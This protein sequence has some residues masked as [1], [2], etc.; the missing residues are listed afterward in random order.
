[1]RQHAVSS[2]DTPVDVNVNVNVLDIGAKTE[3][4]STA[5]GARPAGNPKNH[6]AATA[7]AAAMVSA[8]ILSAS[9]S[10]DAAR[11][12]Q[13]SLFDGRR[14]DDHGQQ[15]AFQQAPAPI[16]VDPNSLLPPE[17]KNLDTDV[18][19]FKRH[20]SI[21]NA[22]AGLSGVG[23]PT[24]S[25]SPRPFPP[26]P[27]RAGSVRLTP[28]EQ[29][30][31]FSS[32]IRDAPGQ[33]DSPFVPRTRRGLRHRARLEQ[34]PRLRLSTS[35][36]STSNNSSLQSS[37]AAGALNTSVQSLDAQGPGA[38]S[39]AVDE[40]SRYYGDQPAYLEDGGDLAGSER[41]R[42]AGDAH[43]NAP[44][45]AVATLCHKVSNAL[46][47]THFGSQ[48]L[49]GE[50][51]DG[52]FRLGHLRLGELV[53]RGGS[54]FNATKPRQRSSSSDSARSPGAG[55]AS[56]DADGTRS[57]DGG[58]PN[59][60][61]GSGGRD[62]DDPDDPN[63]DEEPT[64]GQSGPPDP[65]DVHGNLNTEEKRIWKEGERRLR[66]G[67]LWRQFGQSMHFLTLEFE[68]ERTEFEFQCDYTRRNKKYVY[69]GLS[70]GWICCLLYLLVIRAKLL[71]WVG[72]WLFGWRGGLVDDVVLGVSHGGGDSAQGAAAENLE[73]DEAAG[74]AA[75]HGNGQSL[76]QK[77]IQGQLWTGDFAYDRDLN[78]RL[79]KELRLYPKGAPIPGDFGASNSTTAAEKAGATGA[80]AAGQND[81]Q[82]G[83]SNQAE[84]ATQPITTN[85][86]DEILCMGLLPTGLL[87]IVYMTGMRSFFSHVQFVWVERFGGGLFWLVGKL[88]H[89]VF[90]LASS[91]G[92]C[93][94]GCGRPG[95]LKARENMQTH[96]SENMDCVRQVFW[97][98]FVCENLCCCGFN[99]RLAR[100]LRHT[101]CG[102]CCG[103]GPGS[104]RSRNLWRSKRQS[105][106]SQSPSD[107]GSRE[108]GEGVEL[109][110]LSATS[111]E[112]GSSF[113][114]TGRS[115]E[116]MFWRRSNLAHCCASTATCVL[117]NCCFCC[118]A[119]EA[120]CWCCRRKRRGD[121]VAGGAYRSVGGP[122]TN[123]A[124]GALAP[125][126]QITG[127]ASLE[128][129]LSGVRA[130]ILST[131]GD[132]PGPGF[133]QANTGGGLTVPYNPVSG[134][135][136]RGFGSVLSAPGGGVVQPPA[137]AGDE[138]AVAVAAVP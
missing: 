46:H 36:L 119:K 100:W 65:N 16:L 48:V 37:A 23:S 114:S 87:F 75:E 106:G 72:Y 83:L 115:Q 10:K 122:P 11:A 26:A 134:A 1:M 94:W 49:G 79:A 7:T 35:G 19:F 108:E 136:G 43:D 59:A 33:G 71:G 77:L 110:R 22:E 63:R 84:T 96:F 112:T 2:N 53:P 76:F 69:W 93:C 85:R 137:V 120:G 56:A 31:S 47:A 50:A 55:A 42:R 29:G 95:C 58:Q 82:S 41:Q 131:R 125:P 57:G 52:L 127:T 123:A 126:L 89:M 40:S 92:T 8:S 45:G 130:A 9:K 73:I 88:L 27:T 98:E 105:R 70:F 78:V 64:S 101:C 24:A 129:N 51:Q 32:S 44:R 20:G 21:T 99:K 34:G 39:G 138:D 102:W 30:L 6:A 91:V 135:I 38:Y 67:D 60:G 17:Y 68:V 113:S 104:R 121:P 133:V 74:G 5:A 117:A 81:S 15:A 14:Q 124:R 116:A 4:I 12:G 28:A 86:V 62:P 3:G 80:A 111:R 90:F 54:H 109:Q 66:R 13:P 118:W 103:H 107:R 18:Q 132:N 25:Q 128:N 97:L 61:V